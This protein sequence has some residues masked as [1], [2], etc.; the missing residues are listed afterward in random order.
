M[1]AN[2]KGFSIIEVM[3]AVGLLTLV[4]LAAT[5]FFAQQLKANHFLEFQSKREQLRLAMLGQVLNNPANCKCLFNGA[6]NFSSAGASDLTGYADPHAIGRFEPADCSAGVPNPLV[7]KNGFDGLKLISTS[8][9]NISFAGG[10]YGGELMITIEASKEVAG[11]KT[12]LLKIPVAVLTTDA[13]GGM[14]TFEGCA[15]STGFGMSNPI[16]PGWPNTLNCGGTVWTIYREGEYH[17]Y[18]GGESSTRSDRMS[19]SA[20]SRTFQSRTYETDNNKCPSSID[21][22]TKTIEELVGLGLAR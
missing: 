1:A 2:K 22:Q 14:R 13:G 15:N 21:C 17:C 12:L 9:K 16:F 18:G 3:V 6:A 5:T 8:L 20:S 11:P 19:F 10:T 4:M 7:D